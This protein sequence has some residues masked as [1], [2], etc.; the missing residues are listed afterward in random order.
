MNREQRRLAH[1][2]DVHHLELELQNRALR[3]AQGSLEESRARYAE[4]YDASPV[5]HVTLDRDGVIREVNLMCA[6]L[7]GKERRYLQERPMRTLLA[8]ESRGL[9]DAHLRACFRGHHPLTVELSV[10]RA[11]GGLRTLELVTVPTPAAARPAGDACATCHSALLDITERKRD[12][13]R[14]HD[15]L[16][17]ERA[18]RALAEDVNRLKE[19]FLAIVSH[20]LRSPLTPMMMWVKA[21]R[22]GGLS[23]ALRARAVEALDTCLKVQVA[24]I[25]DLVDVARG[26]HGKLRLE[27]RSLELGPVVGAAVAAIAPAAEAKR[28]SVE[29]ELEPTP[30]WVAGDATRLQQVVGNLLSNAIK[31]TGERGHVGVSLRSS[32]AEVVLTVRDD[33]EGIEPAA[34]DSIFE[35]FRQHDDAAAGRHGGLGLGLTIVRQLVTQHDGQVVARSPGK[36]RGATFIVT[37]P[38]LAAAPRSE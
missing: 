35:P 28:I 13:E 22:A 11:D 37:L 34:L 20:E 9:L 6:S 21:L 14:L 5:G 27:R 26:R 1:E 18:A 4:L 32:G 8:P 29:L 10:P 3:D 19:D 36:G 17:R 30:A 33:G 16:E 24:M 25:D 12:E 23:E 15:L 2:L 7:L 38:R 31:F